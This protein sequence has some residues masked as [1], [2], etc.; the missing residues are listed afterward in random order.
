MATR[1]KLQHAKVQ[2]S[3]LLLTTHVCIFSYGPCAA[4]IHSAVL[5][6]VD[7]FPEV[8]SCK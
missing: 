5:E 6:M 8:G 4:N 2:T 7:V 1:F 3:E